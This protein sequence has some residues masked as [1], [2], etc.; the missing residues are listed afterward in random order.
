MTTSR[1]NP[2]LGPVSPTPP[3]V[4][5]PRFWKGRIWIKNGPFAGV[6]FIIRCPYGVAANAAALLQRAAA[7]GQITRYTFGPL[8]AE[9]LKR[10]PKATRNDPLLRYEPVF[11]DLAESLHIDW[12]A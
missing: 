8:P 12:V 9:Q 3:T 2:D 7:R 11:D 10:L 4:Y 1:L 6:G 5:E